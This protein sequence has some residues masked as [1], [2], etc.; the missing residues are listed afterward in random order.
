M[1]LVPFEVTM[2]C[3]SVTLHHWVR[4]AYAQRDRE[5]G[6][7]GP[8]IGDR[9]SVEGAGAVTLPVVGVAPGEEV[10][11]HA[12]LWLGGIAMYWTDWICATEGDTFTVDRP[13]IMR[14]S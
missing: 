2:P 5:R 11:V 7:Y 8:R 9:V 12:V 4:G 3:D 1:T 13:G 10:E 14:C 6:V